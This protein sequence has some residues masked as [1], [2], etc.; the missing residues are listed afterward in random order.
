VVRAEP[1]LLDVFDGD[2]VAS[3]AF[4]TTAWAL[5]W[6]AHTLVQQAQ[7]ASMRV[8]RFSCL[9]AVAAVGLAACAGS[10]GSMY[11]ATA[12]SC[13]QY[14]EADSGANPGDI[15]YH[16][17]RLM[18]AAVQ[19][20]GG[21]VSSKVTFNQP[22]AGH[23]VPVDVVTLLTNDAGRTVGIVAS[24]QRQ[25]VQWANGTFT[26]PKVAVDSWTVPQNL[27]ADATNGSGAVWTTTTTAR[28]LGAGSGSWKWVVR[29]GS[30][31]PHQPAKY[32]VSVCTGS[33]R[34]KI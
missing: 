21:K 32:A 27:G 12:A 20:S 13:R 6:P 30:Y 2:P 18:Q 8:G 29:L 22:I 24:Q 11:G 3:D 1:P 28:D 26:E 25:S 19:V 15:V 9:V 34:V 7:R 10:G 31:M 5:A 17:L 4:V 23:K 16:S 33:S 14:T